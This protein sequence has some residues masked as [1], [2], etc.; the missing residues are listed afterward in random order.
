MALKYH[1]DRNRAKSDVEQEEAAKKFKDIAEAHGVLTDPEK[2]KKY[3]CGQ[4]DFD[5]DEGFDNMGGRGGNMNFNMGNMGGMGGM[6][7]NR[8]NGTTTFF[9]NGQDMSG[10]GIDPSQLFSMFSGGEGFGGFGGMRG[11]SR[12]KGASKG[13]SKSQ[14][15][16]GFP[17][18]GGFGNFGGFD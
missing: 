12:S 1:P 8:G 17:G 9:M 6:G 10:M 13:S 15:F 11:A 7:G 2:K 4:M 16:D 3:D 5:G 18:F 14:K